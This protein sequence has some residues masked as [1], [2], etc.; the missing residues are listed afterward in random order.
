MLKLAPFWSDPDYGLTP[1]TRELLPRA[2]LL[3]VTDYR[4]GDQVQR[5]IPT[6]SDYRV[7]Q[8][9]DRGLRLY[10]WYANRPITKQMSCPVI[11]YC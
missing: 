8:M 1:I 2:T 3:I 10:I 4:I 6:V 7:R 9:R 5:R 11:A